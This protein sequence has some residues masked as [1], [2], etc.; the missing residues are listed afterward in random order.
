MK[1]IKILFISILVIIISF[2]MFAWYSGFFAT[3]NIEERQAGP[4]HILFKEFTIDYPQADNKLEIVMSELG[5]MG[6]DIGLGVV[7]FYGNGEVRNDDFDGVR[8]CMIGVVIQPQDIT[9][10]DRAGSEFQHKL[11]TRQS[12]IV[13]QFPYTNHFSE[14]AGHYKVYPAIMNYCYKNNY[15]PGPILELH[16]EQG[17]TINY[18]MKIII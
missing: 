11:I 6:F 12:S 14:F 13:V 4:F 7:M 10:I 8:K 2:V 3:V 16:D 18:I 17:K 5:N 15:T 9:M 1:F